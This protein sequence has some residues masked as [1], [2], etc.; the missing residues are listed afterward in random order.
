MN[1]HQFIDSHCHVYASAF[2]ADREASIERA[3][4]V[5]VG[6]MLLPNIDVLAS[7]IQGDVV[8]MIV[9]AVCTYWFYRSFDAPLRRSMA[10]GE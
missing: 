7:D 6:R 8:F 1:T 10:D 9:L 2:S 3:F 4:E 5:G